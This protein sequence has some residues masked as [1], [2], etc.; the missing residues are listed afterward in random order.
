MF[1]AH[2]TRTAEQ[3]TARSSPA[4]ASLTVN[5]QRRISSL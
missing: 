4:L 3:P 1:D 5:R 2:A